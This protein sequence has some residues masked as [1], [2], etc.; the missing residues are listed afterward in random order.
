R[1]DHSM[2]QTLKTIALA[3][4]LAIGFTVTTEAAER[5]QVRMVINLIACVEMP[6]STLLEQRRQLSSSEG[7]SRGAEVPSFA[8]IRL[9]TPY[10]LSNALITDNG[11][12]NS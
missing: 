6:L 9:T 2:S 7:T 10:A 3:G 11:Q 4:A 8:S 1:E 12:D 5:E